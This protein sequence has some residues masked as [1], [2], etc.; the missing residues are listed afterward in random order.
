MLK[1]LCALCCITGTDKKKTWSVLVMP[2]VGH[3][4]GLPLSLPAAK[5]LTVL[6]SKVSPY[7]VRIEAAETRDFWAYGI[8]K[9]Y[10]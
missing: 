6:F 4:Q 8:I 5:V 9:H 10:S 1:R 3:N 2:R 7:S